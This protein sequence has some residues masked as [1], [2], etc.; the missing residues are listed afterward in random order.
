MATLNMD[1]DILKNP[2]LNIKEL[3]LKIDLYKTYI[4]IYIYIYIY[5]I[6]HNNQHN[7]GILN[8]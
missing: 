1:M 4:Y 8:I 5:N 3:D 7:S 6:Y 2:T